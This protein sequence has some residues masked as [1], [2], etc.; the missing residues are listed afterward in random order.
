MMLLHQHVDLNADDDDVCWVT[1]HAFI[2]IK[3]NVFK[4][5]SECQTVWI[6]IRINTLSVLIRV[7]TVCKGYSYMTKVAACREVNFSMS[8]YCRFKDA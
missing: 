2:V 3:V 6:Q 5:L 4:M 8:V 1:F 7:Q